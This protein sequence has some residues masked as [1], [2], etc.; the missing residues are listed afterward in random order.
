MKQMLIFKEYPVVLENK[1]PVTNTSSTSICPVSA[2]HIISFPLTKWT[3]ENTTWAP[4]ALITGL[5]GL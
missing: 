2:L 1:K 3:E 5:R 4:M